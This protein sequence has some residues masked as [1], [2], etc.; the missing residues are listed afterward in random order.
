MFRSVSRSLALL[1]VLGIAIGVVAIVWPTVTIAFVVALF[2]VAAFLG[3]INQAARAF[4]SA[5]AGPV[6]G[7]LLLAAVDVAAGVGSIIWPGITAYALTIWI[8]AWAIVT[9]I[10]EFAMV[11]GTHETVGDRALFGFGGLLSVALGLV[12]FARPDV[13]AVS[14]AT[15]FGL[16]S[17]VYG[18][19]GLVI[20]ARVHQTA[21]QLDK[22]LHQHA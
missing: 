17:L 14:L 20:A 2:A 1:G 4:S 19:W 5:T 6:A 12:L 18:S 9:G 10:G 11:F 3:A 21:S 16:F 22:T 15:V 13:G 7:H 8:G